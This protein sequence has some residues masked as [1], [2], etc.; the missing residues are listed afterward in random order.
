MKNVKKS[1]FYETDQLLR[2]KVLL[3]M[4]NHLVYIFIQDKIEMWLNGLVV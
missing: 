1:S 2:F 3:S 4:I